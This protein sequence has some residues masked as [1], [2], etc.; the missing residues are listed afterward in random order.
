MS[1]VDELDEVPDAASPDATKLR[2]DARQRFREEYGRDLGTVEGEEPHN[3]LD[4]LR[5]ALQERC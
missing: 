2:L 1:A 3:F 5:A 4:S